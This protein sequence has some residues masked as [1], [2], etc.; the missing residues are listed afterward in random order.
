MK[1]HLTFSDIHG[2]INTH[3]DEGQSDNAS[4]KKIPM[5]MQPALRMKAVAKRL[6]ISVEA[7]GTLIRSGIIEAIDCAA[8]QGVG[9]KRQWRVMADSLARYEALRNAVRPI[10]NGDVHDHLPEV[11]N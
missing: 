2:Y 9:S 10:Q 6:G 11:Y 1:I 8:R 7:V 5:S 4:K 3:T